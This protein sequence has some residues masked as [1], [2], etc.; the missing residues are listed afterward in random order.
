MMKKLLIL[1]FF[2]GV[3]ANGATFIL[4]P[5]LDYVPTN[6][7]FVYEIVTSKFQ[8]VIL[9][10]ASFITGIVFYNRDIISFNFYLDAARCE[11][12]HSF[13][14]VSLTNKIPVCLEIETELP[15]LTLS[16]KSLGDCI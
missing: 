6:R 9:D 3:Q 16:R 2:L 4:T 11:D 5:M 13:F 15:S 8:K 10:C 1:I 7:S 12:L 14:Q